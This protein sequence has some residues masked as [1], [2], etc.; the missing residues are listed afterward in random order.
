MLG[1]AWSLS[2]IIGPPAGLHLIESGSRFGWLLCGA[3]GL[4]GGAFVLRSRSSGSSSH[5]KKQGCAARFRFVTK[6]ESTALNVI[7][8]NQN[9]TA[10]TWC[11][12]SR[13]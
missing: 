7:D 5:L 12:P 10:N 11:A 13:V 4:L 2:S 1:L 6:N 8:V 9:G 3:L